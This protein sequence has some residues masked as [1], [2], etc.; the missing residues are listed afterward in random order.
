MQN[1]MNRYQPSVSKISVFRSF[2]NVFNTRLN[3]GGYDRRYSKDKNNLFENA[4]T[5]G[6]KILLSFTRNHNISNMVEAAKKFA[7]ASR[8]RPDSA[9]PYIFLAWLYFLAED[10]SSCKEYVQ[11][12]EKVEP[13]FPEIKKIKNLLLAY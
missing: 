10:K 13:D 5:E 7:E 4:Y 6:L 8:I 1:V 2:L 9:C 3:F 11:M 12:A